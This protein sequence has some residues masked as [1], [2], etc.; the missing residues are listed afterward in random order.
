MTT[1]TPDKKRPRSP[2][3]TPLTTVAQSRHVAPRLHKF[4][5][6]HEL[7]GVI[8]EYTSCADD[9]K[10]INEKNVPETYEKD[11]KVYN[12]YC[13]TVLKNR[14]KLLAFILREDPDIQDA[15]YDWGEPEDFQRNMSQYLFV[16][17]L[18]NKEQ[19]QDQ[20]EE[21]MS[22]LFVEDFGPYQ[23][24]HKVENIQNYTSIQRIKDVLNNHS[25]YFTILL[26]LYKQWQAQ[27]P[28]SP[29]ELDILAT[30]SDSEFGSVKFW[31]K[32]A[33]R[34]SNW[35]TSQVSHFYNLY[36]NI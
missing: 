30:Q 34:R 14:I 35:G 12:F 11:T 3:Q 19:L 10:F 5:L 25:D 2:V 32:I 36:A 29:M 4:L 27:P 6:P 20:A 33:K 22:E 8:N 17:S 7:E 15:Q 18:D 9:I 24:D 26:D 1:R 31:K 21:V 23:L 28:V 13:L 16:D